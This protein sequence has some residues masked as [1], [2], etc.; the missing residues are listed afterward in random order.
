MRIIL[1][2]LI[3]TFSG[4]IF[5]QDYNANNSNTADLIRDADCL[6]TSIFLPNNNELLVTLLNEN[7]TTT[8][9]NSEHY[10][11]QSS[12]EKNIEFINLL[13]E[14]F[15]TEEIYT[16]DYNGNGG[17]VELNSKKIDSGNEVVLFIQLEYG[18]PCHNDTLFI[19]LNSTKKAKK[20]TR[21]LIKLFGENK[22]L[23]EINNRI[24]T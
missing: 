24:K 21:E 19:L 15:A 17:Y 7:T 18:S 16:I 2:I 3:L 22:G 12:K 4:I 20:L 6:T 23:K 10:Y 9:N 5:G 13:S 11:I 1:N 8:D 14:N